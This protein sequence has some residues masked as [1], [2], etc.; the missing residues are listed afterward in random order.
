[1]V[2]LSNAYTY[3]YRRKGIF[4]EEDTERQW[5]IAHHQLEPSQFFRSW[6]SD[7]EHMVSSDAKA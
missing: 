6:K 5:F 4:R 2:F 1:M 7:L 3:S